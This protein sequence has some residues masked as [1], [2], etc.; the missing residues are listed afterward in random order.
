[1]ASPFQIERA[2]TPPL[3]LKSDRL[4]GYSVPAIS[5]PRKSTDP[6][7]TNLGGT[8]LTNRTAPRLNW[9]LLFD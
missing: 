3:C 4:L 7:H 9:P 6:S 2:N 8:F 5:W 1:M